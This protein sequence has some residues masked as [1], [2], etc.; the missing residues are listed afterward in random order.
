MSDPR[1]WDSLLSLDR[2]TELYAEGIQRYGGDPSGPKP[3]CVDGSIGA[4]WM[5]ESYSDPAPGR[6]PRGKEPPSPDSF[7]VGPGRP[8][9]TPPAGH[10]RIVP[11]G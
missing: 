6:Q 5:A 11:I 4:A 10:G 9:P 7:P 8:R 3:S 2:V 1:P